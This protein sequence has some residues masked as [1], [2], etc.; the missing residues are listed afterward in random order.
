[1]TWN[2]QEA[3]RP[4]TDQTIYYLKVCCWGA[5]SVVL[6]EVT[7]L[8]RTMR[9]HGSPFALSV[10][11]EYLESSRLD[12]RLGHR[13]EITACERIRVCSDAKR[14]SSGSASLACLIGYLHRPECMIPASSSLTRLTTPLRGASLSMSSLNVL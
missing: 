8:S 6:A 4:N 12:L 13:N 3:T 9:M 1:M 10:P 5:G 11:N 14:A 7:G 2:L